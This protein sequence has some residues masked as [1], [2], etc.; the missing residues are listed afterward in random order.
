MRKLDGTIALV[1]CEV[2]VFNARL[3]NLIADKSTFLLPTYID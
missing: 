2:A 3:A 1:C